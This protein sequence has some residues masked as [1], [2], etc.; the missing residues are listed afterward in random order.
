MVVYLHGEVALGGDSPGYLAR[1]EEIV[2][3]GR[4]PVLTVQPNG[5]S[6]LLAPILQ[7]Q[8]LRTA[9]VVVRLQQLLDFLIVFVLAWYA[10][11]VLRGRSLFLVFAV[12]ASLVLQP[13]TGT[14]ACS[15]LLLVF[16]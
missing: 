7:G 3:T 5:Y 12:V 1:A 13:F 11:Q 6:I 15:A 16:G 2:R 9:M 14:M 4:L 10:Q 8:P